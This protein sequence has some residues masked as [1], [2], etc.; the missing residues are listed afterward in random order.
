[1]DRSTDLD[2]QELKVRG[3]AAAALALRSAALASRA[4]LAATR[5]LRSSGGSRRTVRGHL[6]RGVL[7]LS[8]P[9]RAA[10]HRRLSLTLPRGAA[11]R[12]VVPA[13]GHPVLPSAGDNGSWAAGPEVLRAPELAEDTEVAPS[14]LEV[15]RFPGKVVRGHFPSGPR[16]PLFCPAPAPVRHRDSLFPFANSL[17]RG[18]CGHL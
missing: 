2:I 18:V 14:L 10:T 7:G 16:P 15:A 6:G 12:V 9:P 1:M 8:A 17:H 13:G 4:L 5:L 3:P 11:L